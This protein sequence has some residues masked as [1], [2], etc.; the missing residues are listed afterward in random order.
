MDFKA[1]LQKKTTLTLGDKRVDAQKLTYK[2]YKKMQDY[3][4]NLPGNIFSL[5]L[6]PQEDFYQTALVIFHHNLNELYDV[7]AVLS[8]IDREY[9][10]EHAGVNEVIDYLVAT[11]K[12]NDFQST[13]KNVKSLLPEKTNPV[14]EQ[15]TSPLSNG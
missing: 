13:L 7:V 1:L 15:A 9:L 2:K 6:T 5:M 8:E 11:V 10:D 12:A 4:Q 3:V 14:P